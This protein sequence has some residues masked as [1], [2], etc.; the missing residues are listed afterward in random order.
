MNLNNGVD[1]TV[2]NHT[3]ELLCKTGSGLLC[4][5]LSHGWGIPVLFIAVT[6]HLLVDDWLMATYKRHG[7]QAT[8]KIQ[9]S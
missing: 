8:G 3:I 1:T 5:L 4:I 7:L 9:N 2:L 6:R